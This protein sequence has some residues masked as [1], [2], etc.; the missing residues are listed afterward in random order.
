MKFGITIFPTD[1]TL[2]PVELAEAV[3]ERGFESLWYAEHSHIPTSRRSPFPSGAE[4]PEKYKRTHD[5]FVA[6]AAGAAVTT[7]LK[8]GTGITLLAQR[9]PI[10]TAKEVASLDVISGGRVLFGVGYGWN[11]E[12][13]GSHGTAFDERRELLREK[14]H[15]MKALWTEDVA[16]YEGELISLEPSWAWPK[17]VQD[18]HPPIIMGAGIGPKTLAH[19]VEFCDGWIPLGRHE[20]REAV[21]TVRR[22]LEDAGRDP[23][24][25]EITKYGASRR[26]ESLDELAELGVDR[27]VFPVESDP[28]ARVIE[29]LDELAEI[30]RSYPA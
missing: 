28:P 24:D 23:A 2:Q 22:G 16:S 4:M 10:W 27:A 29:K 12:E 15:L 11:V 14:I 25:F 6:L 21:T 26:T 9:D 3:E 17:P 20:I 7:D 13:M 19:I 30:A 8:L 5:Q 1:Q 18:P